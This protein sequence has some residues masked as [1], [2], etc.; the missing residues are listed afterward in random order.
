MLPDQIYGWRKKF[1]DYGYASFPMHFNHHLIMAGDVL[2]RGTLHG[3][4]IKLSFDDFTI[5]L[6]KSLTN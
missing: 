3:V 2:S 6:I 5:P 1:A 4:C